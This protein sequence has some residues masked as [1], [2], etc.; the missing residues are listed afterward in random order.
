M[1]KQD[2]AV[3]GPQKVAAFLLSLDKNS[4]A[5]VL[6]SLDPRRCHSIFVPSI[7]QSVNQTVF[8]R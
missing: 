7:S 4:A 3:S 1:S 2:K 6:K 5:A 8:K